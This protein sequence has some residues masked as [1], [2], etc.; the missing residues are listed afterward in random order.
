MLE[1]PMDRSQEQ[2]IAFGFRAA[3]TKVLHGTGLVDYCKP[4]EIGVVYPHFL[5]PLQSC[6]GL[7]VYNP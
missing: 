3:L 4:L 5:L 7:S 1:S 6:K 2:L